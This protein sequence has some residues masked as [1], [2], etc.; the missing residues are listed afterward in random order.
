M[1]GNEEHD[2]KN[3]HGK[4]EE[5]NEDNNDDSKEGEGVSN[6]Q[7]F[8]NIFNGNQGVGVLT[9]PFAVYYG[10]YISVFVITL[11]AIVSNFTAKKLVRCLYE[12]K[13]ETGEQVRVRGTYEDVGEAAGGPYMKFLVYVTITIEQIGYCTALLILCGTIM[14]CSFPQVSL[15]VPQWTMIVFLLVIPYAFVRDIREVRI[16]LI[17]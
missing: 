3:V 7:T 14:H 16:E 1:D 12:T 2:T 10:T 8:W 17:S 13:P 5:S 11:I 6:M 4:T 15:M 9:M